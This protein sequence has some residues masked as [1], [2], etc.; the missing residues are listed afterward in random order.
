MAATYIGKGDMDSV[1]TDTVLPEYPASGIVF[2]DMLILWVV[3]DQ[4]GVTTGII[5]TPSGWTPVVTGGF[6]NSAVALVGNGAVFYKAATGSENGGF[7]TVTRT[8]DTGGL[9]TFSAIIYQ[10]RDA[11]TIED[12]DLKDDGNGDATITWNAVTVGGS[13]RTLLALVGQKDS[14]AISTPTG[15]T[16]RTS[17]SDGMNM[18]LELKD[19]ENVSSDGSVTATGGRTDGWITVHMS[20]YWQVQGGGSFIVN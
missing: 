4:L 13:V 11:N 14:I 7:V 20:I 2:G 1:A 10:Y 12:S 18:T 3:N 15:Y 19:Y 9:T 5:N 8:G 17:D 6:N 16:A